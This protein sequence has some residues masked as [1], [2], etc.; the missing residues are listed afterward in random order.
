MISVIIPCLEDHFINP[1]LESLFKNTKEDIE[2]IVVDDNSQKAFNIENRFLDRVKI[3]KNTEQIGP[4]QCRSLAALNA[5]NKFIFTV[6]SHT[7]FEPDW[8]KV[9][10]EN[11][12]KHPKALVCFPIR[13]ANTWNRNDYPKFRI[14]FGANIFIRNIP[15]HF[16]DSKISE[17]Y[18]ENVSSIKFAS[19]GI[20]KDYYLN[21]R[22]LTDLKQWGSSEL[23]LSIKTWLTGGFIK[24]IPDIV[25]T[26]INQKQ[27]ND[28]Q[29]DI[30]AIYYNKIR[31]AK[32][33]MDEGNYQ[34]F[35]ALLPQN[36]KFVTKALIDIEKDKEIISEYK[37]YYANIMD[38]DFIWLRNKFNIC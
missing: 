2:C 8:D 15:Y 36:D 5:K 34:Y 26:H 3:I 19:Y 1:T 10:I 29:R 12:E 13:L 27:A 22:G 28:F 14:S 33:F 7:D 21:F 11:L 30:S 23:C 4:S 20:N 17:V 18:N 25:F 9:L 6:D 32:T 38:K 31:L 35:T 16:L 37:S 24:I